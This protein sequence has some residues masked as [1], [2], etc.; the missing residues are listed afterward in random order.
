MTKLRSL[1]AEVDAALDIFMAGR[2]GQQFNR[3]AFILADDICEL[4][5]KLYLVSGNA[6]W[7]DARP[8]GGFKSFHEVTT[9]VL[10]ACPAGQDLITR[11]RARRARRNGF[12][13]SA[14]LLDLNLHA[15]DVNDAMRDMLDYGACL[16]G[17]AWDA[18]ISGTRN[19]ETAAV[20]VRLDC[21][22][23]A[24]PRIGQEVSKIFAG[25]RRSEK[26][27]AK[28]CEVA[29]HPDD[30]HLRLAIRNGGKD[31]RDKLSAL[32]P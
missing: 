29:R 11:I 25:L 31:L 14:H 20:I 10:A 4:G 27:T 13:H 28:G 16:F 5:S 23:Y 15:H 26:P 22:S 19:L 2:S 7:S 9:E 12:F 32:L 8:N 17:A 3:V 6:N 30:H 24:D 21:A 18:E 1:V